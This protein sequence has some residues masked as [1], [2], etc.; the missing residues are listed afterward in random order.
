MFIVT[1][2]YPS[3]LLSKHKVH[4][5]KGIGYPAWCYTLPCGGHCIS[6]EY[7]GKKTLRKTEMNKG[8]LISWKSQLNCIKERLQKLYV[9]KEGRC[10][11]TSLPQARKGSQPLNLSSTS[12][13]VHT[14]R[15]I[16]ILVQKRDSNHSSQK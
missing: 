6:H 14:L 11:F 16:N 2:L 10:P 15:E 4:N 7:Y 3:S 12:A 5:H 8:H 9:G 1:F 13:T